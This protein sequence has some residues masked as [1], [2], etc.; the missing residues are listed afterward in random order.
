MGAALPSRPSVIM[1]VVEK[2]TP[3]VLK[4][5][6]EHIDQNQAGPSNRLEHPNGAVAVNEGVFTPVVEGPMAIHRPYVQYT[7]YPADGSDRSKL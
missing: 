2:P 1:P 7:I 6:F 4:R 5:R 3:P